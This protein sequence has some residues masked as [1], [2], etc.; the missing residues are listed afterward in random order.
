MADRRAQGSSHPEDC[1]VLPHALAKFSPRALLRAESEASRHS[2]MCEA[3]GSRSLLLCGLLGGANKHEIRD[4][5]LLGLARERER[6]RADFLLPGCLNL[7]RAAF[8]PNTPLPRILLSGEC[9]STTSCSC[10]ER[11]CSCARRVFGPRLLHWVPLPTRELM[12]VLD[13]HLISLLS[14]ALTA[15]TRAPGLRLL[16]HCV[17]APNR[18]CVVTSTSEDGIRYIAPLA[19]ALR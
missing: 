4:D 11:P 1:I 3:R 14:V 10:K 12:P 16:H 9:E 6:W 19:T 2:R 5:A 17:C 18:A 13:R 8:N 15:L 7:P